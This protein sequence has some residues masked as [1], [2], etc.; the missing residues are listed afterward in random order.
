LALNTVVVKSITT[1]RFEHISQFDVDE[2]VNEELSKSEN[3]ENYEF[4]FVSDSLPGIAP[5]RELLQAFGED[6]YIHPTIA[7]TNSQEGTE[8]SIA[9]ECGKIDCSACH[10]PTE[11]LPTHNRFSPE[12][13]C[14]AFIGLPFNSEASK[15]L[16]KKNFNE[17]KGAALKQHDEILRTMQEDAKADFIVVSIT[18]NANNNTDYELEEVNNLN[19]YHM[20]SAGER[21]I[22]ILKTRKKVKQ[23]IVSAEASVQDAMQELHDLIEGDA[24]SSDDTAPSPP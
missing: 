18:L 8:E 20:E 12:R 2:F 3:D 24:A 9:Y 11:P 7:V 17:F 16:R 14:W 15:A 1:R 22:E 4:R 19:L 23:E 21:L 6:A 5:A 10:F 13:E